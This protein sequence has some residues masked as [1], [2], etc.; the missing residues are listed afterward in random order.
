LQL[1]PDA[2][3]E[4]HYRA[5]LPTGKESMSHRN[6]GQGDERRLAADSIDTGTELQ[7]TVSGNLLRASGLLILP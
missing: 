2:E 3:K 5:K 4:N 7:Q 6:P 1:R